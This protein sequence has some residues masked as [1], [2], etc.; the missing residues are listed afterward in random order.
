MPRPTFTPSGLRHGDAA[1]LAR[2]H[3]VTRQ[4]VL[5]CARGRRQGRAALM[6]AIAK[7]RRAA[8]AERERSPLALRAA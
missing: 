2:Q 3:G 1:E 5:E 4:H 7:A 6:R 8:M